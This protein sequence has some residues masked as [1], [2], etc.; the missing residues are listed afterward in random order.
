MLGVIVFVYVNE[1]VKLCLVLYVVEEILVFKFKNYYK[2]VVEYKDIIKLLMV[3][4]LVISFIKVEVMICFD[5]FIQFYYV[6]DED[7][8]KIVVVSMCLY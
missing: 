3:F 7:K 1:G 5:L 4:I 8:E 6:W 2:S